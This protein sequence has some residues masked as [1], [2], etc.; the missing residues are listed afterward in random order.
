MSITASTTSSDGTVGLNIVPAAVRYYDAARHVGLTPRALARE[1]KRFGLGA[2]L[3]HGKS[4]TI[5]VET[6]AEL[7]RLRTEEAQARG[8]EALEQAEI[9]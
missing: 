1:L 8:T 7:D 9:A 4:R 6:L 2:P 3:G 5:H